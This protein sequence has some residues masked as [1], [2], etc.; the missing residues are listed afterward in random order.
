MAHRYLL[1]AQRKAPQ[2][3][4]LGFRLAVH[5]LGTIVQL[6][7]GEIPDRAI[8]RAP[9]SRKPMRAYLKLVQAVRLGDLGAFR[10][11]MHDHRDTFESDGNYSLVVRLR[12]NVIRAGLRNIA[13]AY[14][15]ISLTAAAAKLALDNPSDMESIAAKVHR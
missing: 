14:T 3:S 7:L 12:Q 9:A 4:A 11:A 8:F 10:S 13:L 2:K 5:R 1:Q 6:L 15:R